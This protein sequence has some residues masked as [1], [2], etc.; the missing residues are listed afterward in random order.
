MSD[1]PK[2]LLPTLLDLPDERRAAVE[3]E[4]TP[5]ARSAAPGELAADI[6]HDL[7]NP[8]FAVLGLVDL[9]LLDAAPGFG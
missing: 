1:T 4:L 3:R 5:L 7:A 9:L 8:L 6:G 2:Y